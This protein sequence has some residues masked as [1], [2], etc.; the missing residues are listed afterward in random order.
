ME[1]AGL[2]D[3]VHLLPALWLVR[4]QYPQAELHVM[5]SAHA[6]DLFRLT[7]WVHRVWAYPRAP[8]A[9]GFV[10]NLGWGRRLRAERFDLLV[11]TTGSDRSSLLSWLSR[12]PVRVARRPADGGPPGWRHLFTHVMEQPY[13]LEPM[14]LQKW[15]A[16]QQVGFAAGPQPEFHITI[17]PEFRRA[18]AIAPADEG[19]Y[20]HV[21]PCTTAD[22]RELPLAQQAELLR[23]LQAAHPHLKLAVSCA[24]NARERGKLQGLLGLLGFE[25]WRVYAGTLDVPRLAA[26]I[27]KAALHL[28]GDTGSLHIALMTQTP[29]VAWFRA[30]RGQH[31][32]IPLFPQYRVVVA[33][34]GADDALHGIDTGALLAAAQA[35]LPA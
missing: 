6:A 35:L 4:Q 20:I 34:G 17:D 28:C 21:S 23:G 24:P 18:A 25:P 29:T 33:D 27:E 26:V 16:L 1:L 9:P 30:H 11:N 32:W 31:E 12:A 7:P 22:R 2:G 19:R 10:A 15:K 8:R 14:Y 13:Y 5:A 3:N